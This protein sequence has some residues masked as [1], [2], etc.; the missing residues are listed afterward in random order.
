MFTESNSKLKILKDSWFK[1]AEVKKAAP[2]EV[3]IPFDHSRIDFLPE[4]LP[5]NQHPLWQSQPIALRN[6]V[7]SYGWVVYNLRTIHIETEIVGTFCQDIINHQIKIMEHYHYE[8]LLAQTLVD[9]AYHVLISIEGYES[10]LKNRKLPRLALPEFQFHQKIKKQLAQAA[11]QQEQELIMLGVVVASEILISAYLSSISE[12]DI[13]QPLFRH[14]TYIH[15]RD[16][17]SHGGVFKHIVERIIDD[18][19]NREQRFLLHIIQCANEWFTDPEL[20]IWRC[21]LEHCGIS[22]VD[23]IL[24]GNAIESSESSHQLAYAKINKLISNLDKNI[25]ELQWKKNTNLAK[26]NC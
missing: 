4:L 18:L 2:S 20:D 24:D 9:E 19:S 15:W 7:L 17:L 13:V 26:E 12:S 25:A 16:E 1:K 14:I 22:H 10:V 5:F 8:G 21:I 11:N 3:E 23:A 6:K